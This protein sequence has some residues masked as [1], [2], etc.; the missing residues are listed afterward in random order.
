MRIIPITS[1]CGSN[2][3]IKYNPS[4]KST[5]RNFINP[6]YFKLESE[7]F[8]YFKTHC[9]PYRNNNSTTPCYSFIKREKEQLTV[10]VTDEEINTIA[11]M[12]VQNPPTH[13]S[14]ILIQAVIDTLG[15][16]AKIAPFK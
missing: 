5:P 2:N 11:K 3:G 7:G 14:N 16:I 1:N 15:N 8:K 6:N 9:L 4:V 13:K 12:S 10:I